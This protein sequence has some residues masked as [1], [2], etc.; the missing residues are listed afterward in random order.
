MGSSK[1]KAFVRDYAGSAPAEDFAEST[2]YYMYQPQYLKTIDP[3]KYNFIK[4]KVF[5]GKEFLND[6]N[7]PV[8]KDDIM[9]SCIAG[10]GDLKFYTNGPIPPE[11]PS[12]CLKDYVNNFKV[13][14]PAWCSLNKDQIQAFF[15]D[16]VAG[17]IEKMNSQFKACHAQIEKNIDI[18]NSEG[19]FQSRCATDKC[20]IAESLKPKV[21]YFSMK[22]L[23]SNAIKNAYDKIGKEKFISTVLINGLKNNEKVSADYKLYYQQDFLDNAAAG[24]MDSFKQQNYKFDDIDTAKKKS[25]DFLMMDKTTTEALSSFQTEV[26]KNATKSKEKNLVLIKSWAQKQNLNDTNLYNNLAETMTKYGKG[27]F[28]FN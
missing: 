18:C 3:N 25:S 10:A 21:S 28:G 16:Q 13:T 26:L 17:D 2:A 27:V 8:N 14:D 9:K 15:K 24:I 11:I 6:L 5:K 19:N 20:D 7:I 1:D 23:H 22:A 12:S 4:D